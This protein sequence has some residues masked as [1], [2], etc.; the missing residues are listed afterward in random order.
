MSAAAYFSGAALSA[1]VLGP[2]TLGYITRRLAS[3]DHNEVI[4]ALAEI[5]NQILTCRDE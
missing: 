5:R 1:A 3:R 2:V 4:T